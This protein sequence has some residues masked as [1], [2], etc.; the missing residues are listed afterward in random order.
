MEQASF[1][2]IA[3]HAVD[4][5]HDLAEAVAFR[6]GR[7]VDAWAVV[8]ALESEGWRDVDA[9]ER[10]GKEDLFG[11]A[12]GLYPGCVEESRR[13]GAA[14]E[15]G[16]EVEGVWSLTRRFALSYVRGLL[17]ALPVTGQIVALVAL[18][19]SLWASVR[20][21]EGG[22]TMIALGTLASFVTTA[23]FVQALA[24]E[25]SRLL[26]HRLGGQARRVAFRIV[27]LGAWAVLGTAVLAVLVNLVVPYYPFV[28][29]GIGVMYYV[30]LGWLWLALALLYV[31]ER[32]VAVAAATTLG[33]LPVWGAVAGL[34]WNIHA[35]HALGL[36]VS[37]AL[38]L[39]WARRLGAR[40]TADAGDGPQP[41]LPRDSTIV[42]TTLPYVAY[43]V[44]YFAVLFADRVVAW[45]AS[46]DDPLAFPMWFRTEYELGMDWALVV[47][48]AVLAAIPF[49]VRRMVGQIHELGHITNPT[50]AATVMRRQY[51]RHLA[52]L[53]VIGVGAL[54][55]AWAGGLWMFDHGPDLL[56]PIFAPGVTRFVFAVASV[57]YFF[58]GLGLMNGLIF[59]SQGQPGRVLGP[60]TWALALDVGVGFV[61]T[62]VWGFEHAGWGLLAA[63]GLFAFLTT[64]SA[65]RMLRRADFYSYVAY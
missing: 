22:A 28:L 39:V 26:G 40:A 30:L 15:H 23:G 59:L 42:H 10:F 32:L 19:Y 36:I 9:K 52:I 57:S 55:A 41:P 48:F 60:L 8:A 20:L 63:S 44:L 16:P 61:V 12:D 58:L 27:R 54:G 51:L 18:G 49:P 25:T 34:G 24:H 6:I 2:P 53:T 62:R 43:G 37:I 4:E 56:T 33:I 47:L 31:E 38:A 21:T 7:P 29:V 1:P 64:G 13:L 14:T 50:F 5:E 17:Y 11:L 46:G 45:S 65:L 3:P 35:A